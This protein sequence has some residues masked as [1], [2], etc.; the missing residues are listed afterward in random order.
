MRTMTLPESGPGYCLFHTMTSHQMTS[1]PTPI[2]E[3][4][5]SSLIKLPPLTVLS[6][7]AVGSLH[8]ALNPSTIFEVVGKLG[9]RYSI[10]LD[11]IDVCST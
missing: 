4:Y 2:L 11:P 8:P 7:R 1:L 10:N 6:Q 5:C 9:K 3:L